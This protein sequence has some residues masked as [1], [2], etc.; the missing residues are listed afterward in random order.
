MARALVGF[1]QI[2]GAAGFFFDDALQALLNSGF[3]FVDLFGFDLIGGGN[4]TAADGT[5]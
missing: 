4:D 5:W 3:K 2:A 1:G